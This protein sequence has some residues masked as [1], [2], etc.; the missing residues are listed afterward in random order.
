MERVVIV[1]A[2][3][4]GLLAAHELIEK[5]EVIVFDKR[6]H[7]GGTGLFSDG[8]LTFHPKIGGDLMEFCTEKEA[9]KI[10]EKIDKIFEELGITEEK[11][12]NEKLKQLEV[13]ATK[14]GMK[15]LPARQKHIGSDCLPKVMEIFKEKLEKKGVKFRLGEEVIDLKLEKNRVRGIK[16]TKGFTKCDGLLIAPGRNGS[17]WLKDTLEK[18][19]IKFKFNPVDIGVRVETSAMVMEEVTSIMYDP[20]F[21]IRTKT[22]DD[23]VRTFCV[24]PYGF[25][26]TENYG[27]SIF[28]VNGHSLY[29]KKSENTN[30]ALIVRVA[31]T[32][33]LEDTTLYGRLIANQTNVLGGGKPLIQRLGDLRAGRRSTWERINRSHIKPT[34]TDVTP[35]DI[36]MSYPFRLICNII[37]ALD[38]LNKVI[39][40]INSD[41]TLLYAPE[42]KFYAR[43]VETNEY[44]QTTIPNLF[45]AGDGAGVSRGVV[46]AAATGIIAAN[47]MKKFL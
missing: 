22:Y 44:L 16:S 18:F 31:L 26:T 13:S 36:S 46:G 20:K 17:E 12:D 7:I 43:R 41:S 9:E 10:L 19:G 38:S 47:G 40:G 39:G 28:G 15:F 45:V 5:F 2:G 25:V 37:E 29:S 1:G 24:C 30:F 21:H 8:K 14:A 35:G 3:P 11:Y 4:A 33:P 32:K 27:N 6:K 34:L 42:V 23:F